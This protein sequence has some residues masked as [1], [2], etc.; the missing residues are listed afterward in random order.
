MQRFNNLFFNKLFS[1]TFKLIGVLL[2]LWIFLIFLIQFPLIQNKLV[3]IATKKLSESLNTEVKVGSVRLHFLSYLNV[4]D[5]LIRDL[6]KDTLIAV[7]TLTNNYS[8]FNKNRFSLNIKKL[9]IDGLKI[10]L[11]NTK[12]DSTLNIVKLFSQNTQTT[13]SENTNSSPKS[14]S[15]IPLDVQEIELTNFHI[16][17]DRQYKDEFLEGEAKRLYLNLNKL[18]L[19]DS[20]KEIAEIFI[21]QPHFTLHSFPTNWPKKDFS[22][23][24]YLNIPL[25]LNVAKLVINNGH[26]RLKDDE[27]RYQSKKHQIS[28]TDL[29]ISKINTNFENIKLRKD[30]FTGKINHLS[31]YEKC[32]LS[33]DTLKANLF[34]NSQKMIAKNLLLKTKQSKFK[35]FLRFDYKHMHEI[36]RFAKKVKITS[37]MKNSYF[38]FDD[39]G[40]FV[41]DI[42]RFSQNKIVYTADFKGNLNDM[43]VTNLIGAVNNNIKI[44]SDVHITSLFPIKDLNIN[45]KIESIRSN[46]LG[47]EQFYRGLALTKNMNS[48]GEISYE[49][50]YNGNFKVFTLNGKGKSQLGDILINTAK[51][52]FTEGKIPKYSG[53]IEVLDFDLATL[54]E[55]PVEYKHLNAKL[56]A[57]GQGLNFKDLNTEAHGEIYSVD[58]NNYKYRN[59][60]FD[61]NFINKLFKGSVIAHDPNFN[62][63][64]SGAISLSES[65]PS[66]S[67]NL[68]LNHV[69]LKTLNFVD[70][71]WILSSDAVMAFDG[72]E[73]DEFNGVLEFKNIKVQDFN[74]FQPKVYQFSDI[75]LKSEILNSNYRKITIASNEINGSM[76]GDFKP[77]ELP[78]LLKKYL[79]TYFEFKAS[80]KNVA[81]NDNSYFELNLNLNNIKNYV[82]LFVGNLKNIGNGSVKASYYGNKNDLS[83]N[84]NLYDTRIEN[85][86]I[87]N[88]SLN[89]KSSLESFN[90]NFRIDTIFLNGK[91]A[92]SPIL[93]KLKDQENGL[94]F[95]AEIMNKKDPNFVEFNADIKKEKDVFK[96]KVLPFTQ[97]SIYETW[98][99]DADNVVEYNPTTNL[100][101]INDLTFYKENQKLRFFTEKQSKNKLYTQFES[102][103]IDQIISGFLPELD[104]IKGQVDGEIITDHFLLE[105]PKSL[106]N[107]NFNRVEIGNELL[108]DIKI[109]SN[110][111]NNK[112]HS[113]IIAEGKYLDL[114]I[115]GN[116]FIDSKEDSF[117]YYIKVKSLNPRILNPLLKDFV[118]DMNG[119]V[120]ANLLL[121]GAIKRPNLVGDVYLDSVSTFVNTIHTKYQIKNQ[122]VRILPNQFQF[123][124]I[125]LS[126]ELNNQ[127]VLN[128]KIIHQNL[129]DFELDLKASSPQFLCLN[130]NEKH[131]PNF[132]GRVIANVKE[133]W[134]Q[135]AISQRITIG[136]KAKNLAGSDI[137][138][139]LNN[140]QNIAQHTFFEFIDKS[141]KKDTLSIR[142]R[143]RKLSGV[144][145]DFDFEVDETGKLQIIFDPNLDDRIQ[146]SGTGR[147]AFKMTPETDMDIKGSYILS[148]G[149]YLFTYQNFIQRTFYL[150]QGGKIQFV[151]DPYLSVIDASALFKARASA[152]EIVAAFYG[153]NNTDPEVITASKSQVKANVTLYM[154]NQLVKP[155]ISYDI[156]IE[157]NNP[158]LQNAFEAIKTNTKNNDN[159]MN[160]QVFALLALQRFLP[161]TVTGFENVGVGTS[162]FSNTAFDIVTGKLSSVF[163][164][165]VQNTI[166]GLNL[167]FK[168]RN[169]SQQFSNEVDRRN[170]FKVAA[171]K[172]LFNDRFLINTGVNYDFGQNSINNNNNTFFGG[173]IDIEYKIS[174]SGNLRGKVYSTLDNDPLNAKYINKTGV[175]I[176]YGKEFDNLL[177]FLNLRKKKNI[178]FVPKN[179]SKDSF[180][181]DTA[182]KNLT[183]F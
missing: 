73:I 64:S 151:G 122:F 62:L 182:I 13:K 119:A 57:I 12:K 25:R 133:A 134:F 31:A 58:F 183:L 44:K 172:Q 161:P 136:S 140:N 86:I 123:N 88:I 47:I 68:K 63:A 65:N 71:D 114:N 150:N 37:K 118:Y 159:E 154:K 35:G 76:Q 53:N 61:G 50:S 52:D 20:I 142:N 180:N 107:I 98:R 18:K 102:I 169:Y 26:V 104:L 49:G 33:I 131:N 70:K 83:I 55:S 51:F 165:W 81:I 56:T 5:V 69:N 143:S 148:K 156:D 2:L 38:A 130:T 29:D 14:K 32:G 146:C 4:K 138:I 121:A 110:L 60:Q 144:N 153:V 40:Y 92:A 167:D 87:P 28:F 11:S 163:T 178:R 124:Q 67:V 48:L 19:S 17:F 85:F 7:N 39:L 175:S 177:D 103:K 141:V 113:T 126:D 137:T 59:I 34:M 84:A 100:I 21:D 9:S 24:S 15:S 109:K 115:D 108:G 96:F 91:I 174:P 164:E 105:K 3:G 66:L 101:N 16:E 94:R 23:P 111:E 45:A 160:R 82:S 78:D 157:Q 79:I 54:I 117:E 132:Y 149:T 95:N 179:Q 147:I 10:K 127:G 41:E 139:A 120:R 171:S 43:K 135:G 89:S 112:I 74:K 129:H 166:S 77:S 152:Q 72:N 155:D 46:K 93:L 99:V 168:Y 162:D 8:I 1:F 116:F 75:A 36:M 30:G 27:G 170:E 128:G 90:T 158:T 125:K 181:T 42:Q 173:D 6:D 106:V 176:Y 145:L 80:D 97:Y 22:I